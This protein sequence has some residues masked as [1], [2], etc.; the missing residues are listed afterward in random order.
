MDNLS[1]IRNFASYIAHEET[2]M[3]NCQLDGNDL[4]EVAEGFVSTPDQKVL[5]ITGRSDSLAA[6]HVPGSWTARMDQSPGLRK[7]PVAHM[8]EA[9]DEP[10]VN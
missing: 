4:K 10:L 9:T 7:N 8:T 5:C 1:R 6:E 3:G 2:I